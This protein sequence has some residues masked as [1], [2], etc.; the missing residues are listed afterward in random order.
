M[1]IKDIRESMQ[2]MSLISLMLNEGVI[3]STDRI[4]FIDPKTEYKKA[5]V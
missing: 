5:I 2:S 3:S 4:I 1:P